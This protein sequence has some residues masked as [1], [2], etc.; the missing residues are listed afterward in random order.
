MEPYPIYHLDP[1]VVRDYFQHIIQP[2]RELF[3]RGTFPLQKN[4]L[5]LTVVGSRRATEYGKQVCRYLIQGLHGYPLVIISGLAAGIDTVAH[6]SALE[7][8]LPIIAFPGSGLD[9]AS[10]YPRSSLSLAQKILR[11]GGALVSE[12][13]EQVV[14]NRWTF[15]AR[16]RLMAGLGHATLVIEGTEISGSRMTARMALDMNREVLTVP[17][18]IFSD[19]TQCPHELIRQGAIPITSSHD[20][21][22]ALGFHITPQP[23][24]DLFH[25]CNPEEQHILSLLHA[26][27]RKGDLIRQSN[28]PISSAQVLLMHMEMKGLIKEHE[29]MIMRN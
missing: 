22:E 19:H 24:L 5:F 17:G 26:P 23:P 7:V 27:C 14:G 18:S 2:P 16:N 29:G 13:P 3:I 25:Q 6:E 15:P 1:L 9:D 28:L 20:I 12:Y 4:Y 8:G 10:L 21:L 11:A